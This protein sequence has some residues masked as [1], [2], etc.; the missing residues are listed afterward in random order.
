MLCNQIFETQETK[1]VT[2][3][4]SVKQEKLVGF[5]LVTQKLK[6]K[7]DY[8]QIMTQQCR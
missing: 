3:Y 1:T 2:I 4:S 6:K 5:W 8:H 7:V